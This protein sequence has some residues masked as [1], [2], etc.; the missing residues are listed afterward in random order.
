MSTGHTPG[1]HNKHPQVFK[2]MRES[3]LQKPVPLMCSFLKYTCIKM[4]K[5]YAQWPERLQRCLHTQKHTLTDR[6]RKHY[7]LHVDIA[8]H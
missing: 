4:Y 2:V 7:G 6:T 1:V 5:T 3:H 8:N